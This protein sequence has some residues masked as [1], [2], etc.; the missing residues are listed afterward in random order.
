MKKDLY[1][2]LVIEGFAEQ[3]DEELA[4]L[5]EN[6][7]EPFD[8][9]EIRIIPQTLSIDNLVARLRNQEIDLNT[10]FQRK[11]N[12]WKSEVQSRL[13]ESLMLKLPLPAFYFDASVDDRWLVVD[14]LQRLSTLKN[15]I[16][17]ESLPLTGLD[18][19]KS[20]D[21]KNL[22]FSELPRMMQRRILEANV[23]CFLISPGT[24]QK[25]KYNVFKRI[26]TGALS[27]NEME[28]RN[29]LNQGKAS[30]Y[31]KNFTE[32]DRFRSL[33]PLPNER[34]EDRELVLRCIAFMRRSF[35]EYESPLGSFLDE[36]MEDLQNVSE[37][38]F[39]QISY[40][41]C[42]SIEVS[43]QIWGKHRF[44]RSVI[45]NDLISR[46][47][48]K[49][50]L[51][52]YRLNSALFEAWVVVLSKLS[53][54]EIEKILENKDGLESDYMQLFSYRVFNESVTTST[55]S[56]KAVMNRFQYI[57]SLVNKYK[58]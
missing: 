56:K 39:E 24:P 46:S 2:Q 33:I 50:D 40:L 32:S 14:G 11:A 34:M 29:A 7:V 6:M 52:K 5:A 48:I 45:N 28:I 30:D 4:N 23:T 54:N 38:E 18:I 19:L 10:A 41:I 53:D 51:I 47:V 26:N 36:A 37:T 27:L 20:Y 9:N 35:S 3:A 55:A 31:L 13:V 57:E 43:T 25:V 12:L 16:I 8:P 42:R 17:D 44:S 22:H 15:F 21:S 49:N 58:S 1:G